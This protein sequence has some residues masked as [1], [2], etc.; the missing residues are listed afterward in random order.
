MAT[1]AVRKLKTKRG[2]VGRII[3]RFVGKPLILKYFCPINPS[4]IISGICWQTTNPE[5]LLLYSPSCLISQRRKERRRCRH[6]IL[7]CQYRKTLVLFPLAFWELFLAS[8]NQTRFSPSRTR[9]KPVPGTQIPTFHSL[10]T[11]FLF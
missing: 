3:L 4:S 7:M 1:P 2:D 10:H 8:Y 5:V 11:T 9:R 6:V